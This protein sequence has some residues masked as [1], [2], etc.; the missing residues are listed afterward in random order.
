METIKENE[1]CSHEFALCLKNTK[2]LG[3]FSL[4]DN[5]IRGI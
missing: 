2:L 1:S 3:F 5:D 4:G